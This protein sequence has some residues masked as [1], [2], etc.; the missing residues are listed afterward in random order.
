MITQTRVFV[1]MFFKKSKSVSLIVN[2]C[3]SYNSLMTDN[4][5]RYAIDDTLT[6]GFFDIGEDL[7]ETDSLS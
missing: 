1:K 6:D 7:F 3:Q 4:V 2:S 5:I